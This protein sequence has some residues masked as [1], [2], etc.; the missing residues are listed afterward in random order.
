[1]KKNVKNLEMGNQLTRYANAIKEG[2]IE[3][4][5][6]TMQFKGI[7]TNVTLNV[8]SIEIILEAL[9]SIVELP[10]SDYE[11][12]EESLQAAREDNIIATSYTP[13]ELYGSCDVRCKQYFLCNRETRR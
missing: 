9:A 3:D 5:V 6:V 8:D 11:F 4:E 10:E 1:M 12:S 2:L 7:E 13:C